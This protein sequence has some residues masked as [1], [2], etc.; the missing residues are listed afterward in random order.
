VRVTDSTR[1]KFGGTRSR[2]E[3]RLGW[4]FRLKSTFGFIWL[5]VYS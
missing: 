4:Y 1:L 2:H 3:R 5:L